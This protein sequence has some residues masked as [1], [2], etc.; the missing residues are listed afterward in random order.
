M[1]GAVRSRRVPAGDLLLKSVEDYHASYMS[2]HWWPRTELEENRAMTLEDQKDGS[3]V[4]SPCLGNVGRFFV[5][6]VRTIHLL[7]QASLV[8]R[9]SLNAE[10]LALR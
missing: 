10:I 6:I 8:S 5:G 7:I 4:E 9:L 2:I 1:G 3:G